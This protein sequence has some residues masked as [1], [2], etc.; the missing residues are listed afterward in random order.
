MAGPTAGEELSFFRIK[1]L[2]LNPLPGNF[3]AA[4]LRAIHGYIFQDSPEHAPG[5]YRPENPGGIYVKNRA[6]EATPA[7]YHVHY[8]PDGIAPA[9]D[10]ALKRFGGPQALRGLSTDEAAD[11]LATLYGDLDHAHPFR[12]GNS[13]TLRHFTEQLAKESGFDLDWSRSNADAASRDH[14]YIARDLAV[15]ERAFPG[16]DRQRAM[17]TNDRA[18]YEAWAMFAGR[19][20]EHPRLKDVLRSAVQARD[21]AAPSI[22][23]YEFAASEARRLL[24]PDA[25][26][27][28]AAPGVPYKGSPQKT[29]KIVR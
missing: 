25:K 2:E 27:D 20:Q 28:T 11:K 10:E 8:R 24:G 23:G 19:H 18:E 3:D 22:V 14:L 13:R 9:V 7:R 26:V 15:T 21:T 29:E 1:E 5:Q 12:E 4:H 16:L 6:L 17:D